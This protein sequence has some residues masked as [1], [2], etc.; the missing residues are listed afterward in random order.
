MVSKAGEA[1]SWQRQ[2]S[3]HRD[4]I[5]DSIRVFIALELPHQAKEALSQ[6]ISALKQDISTGVRWVDPSG[7]HLNLKFLGNIQPSLTEQVFGAMNQASRINDFGSPDSGVFQLGLAELGVFPNPSRPRV[8]WA[9]IQGDLTILAGLQA[10]VEEA[11]GQIGFTPEQRPYRPHLTLGR[12][13]EGVPPPARLKIGRAVSQGEM[14]SSQPWQ[15]DSLHLIRSDRRPEGATY[16]S[17]VSVP[18]SSS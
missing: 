2:L 6:T 13:R 7:I 12:V 11:A 14:A 15:V 17:L 10:R 8:L 16:T 4:R 3:G 9:G 1:P 18:L 5:A